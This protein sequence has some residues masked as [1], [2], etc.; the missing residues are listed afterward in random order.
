MSALKTV[1]RE[2]AGEGLLEVHPRG[3]GHACQEGL[4]RPAEVQR[5]PAGV[6][7]EPVLDVR[8]FERHVA[9]LTHLRHAFP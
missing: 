7:G 9:L 8:E 1:G 3:M 4:A 2:P 6:W 5:R